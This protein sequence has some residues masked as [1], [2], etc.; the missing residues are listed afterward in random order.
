MASPS[1]VLS[2]GQLA[3]LAEHGEER[4]AEVGDVLFKVGDRRYPLIAII[5]GEAAVL[6]AA[7]AEIIRHGPSG[8]LGETNLLSGQTVYLTAVVTKPMRY[9]AVERE[10]LKTLLIEDGPLSDLLLS[11]FV[12]R[13]EGL[14]SRA[15]VGMDIIGPQSSDATRR[16]VDFAR[17]NRLPATWL[18]TSH[19]ENVAR[20]RPDRGVS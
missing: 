5:E 11:T 10:E 14:Q 1:A 20:G 17:R 15:G 12:A 4:R 13:R 19:A 7:G 3:L 8:F 6:D 16:M 9:I 2:Q 18:D